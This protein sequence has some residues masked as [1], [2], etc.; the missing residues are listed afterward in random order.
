MKRK[1]STFNSLLSTLLLAAIMTL[2]ACGKDNAGERTDTARDIY[3]TVADETGLADLAGNTVHLDT[4]VQWENLLEH[5]CDI[6]AGGDQL[7]FC[8]T[9]RSLTKDRTTNVPT[10][11]STNDREELKDW[12][13]AMEKAGKTVSVTFN[14]GTWNGRAYANLGNS[15]VGTEPQLFNGTIAFIPTPA[16]DNP[17]MGGLVMALQTSPTQTYIIAIH[18]MLLWFD[19]EEPDHIRE[20]I[21]GTPASLTGVVG[22]HTDLAGNE[23][24]FIELEVPENGVIEL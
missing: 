20:L 11:I 3:Y 10:T 2:T 18:G 22:S 1:L 6:A 24:Q 23:F 17:P 13:K 14:N 19:D 15:E 7:V 9:H 8:S 12:M 16:L 5:F 4:E 21:S